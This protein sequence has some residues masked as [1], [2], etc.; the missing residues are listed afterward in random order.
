MFTEKI[1][2]SPQNLR[3]E[4]TNSCPPAPFSQKFEIPTNPF[5]RQS[6]GG[7]QSI[8]LV[9]REYEDFESPQ[10]L[11]NALKMYKNGNKKHSSDRDLELTK[12]LRKIK[13]ENANNTDF[14]K[15]NS[16]NN[17]QRTFFGSEFQKISS[18][19]Q[20][21]EEVI[22][23]PI[24]ISKEKK[25]LK[26]T[27]RCWAWLNC[28]A[29]VLYYGAVLALLIK[30]M[31]IQLKDEPYSLEATSGALAY[32]AE[33]LESNPIMSVL[34]IASTLNECPS[35]YDTVYLYTWP[36]I[37]SGCYRVDEGVLVPALCNHAVPDPDYM[38]YSLTSQA[39]YNWK[40]N[41]LCVTRAV[42]NIDYVLATQCENGYKECSPGLCLKDS[43]SCPLT[44]IEITN[45]PTRTENVGFGT[46]YLNFWRE[47]GQPPLVSITASVNGL[48]C[49]STK[50]EPTISGSFYLL[51][52]DRINGCASFGTDENSFEIDIDIQQSFLAYNNVTSPFM[53]VAEYQI[54]ILDTSIIL[55]GRTKL[56]TTVN[57]KC[58]NVDLDRIKDVSK[59]SEKLNTRV[60]ASI[61]TALTLHSIIGLLL[62]SYF[63]GRWWV[64][65]SLHEAFWKDQ[66]SYKAFFITLIALE[67]IALLILTVYII[68]YRSYLKQPE[69]YFQNF[70]SLN[71]FGESQA[72]D[73]LSG[74]SDFIHKTA[75]YR[76]IYGV[77]SFAICLVYLGIIILLSKC[78]IKQRRS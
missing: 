38:M 35:G 25:R 19:R 71:C 5:G 67:M 60:S 62:V 41:I 3:V 48:P 22:P 37:Q 46:D 18:D 66:M 31:V 53:K 20:N 44:K 51:T 52:N 32:I 8:E 2:Y 34:P 29:L 75:S 28:L 64:N 76:L 14:K 11:E 61:A 21:D 36:G 13:S 72:S 57:L 56:Q 40:G 30:L 43:L 68:L 23:F 10:D 6:L 74:Y 47:E 50:E 33:N 73:V 16:T 55:T 12:P 7:V 45:Q 39:L 24:P 4:H 63:C 59:A 69:E 58:L 42:R 65:K 15:S 54:L 1:E 77:I 27:K 78:I 17:N 49:F 26:L 9:P 70:V